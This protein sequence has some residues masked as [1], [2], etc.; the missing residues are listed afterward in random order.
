MVWVGFLLYF[1]LLSIRCC[2]AA[3]IKGG[4]KKGNDGG[5]QTGKTDDTQDVS[6][7]GISFEEEEEDIEDSS[8]R[9]VLD[10]ASAVSLSIPIGVEEKKKKNLTMIAIAIKMK[11]I[12]GMI[13]LI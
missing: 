12:T 7:T 9:R 2:L 3:I 13:F 5:P 1:P 11:E 8:S 6:D 10:R 4:G